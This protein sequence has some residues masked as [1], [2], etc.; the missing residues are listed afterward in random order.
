MAIQSTQLSGNTT[1][2]FTSVNSNAITAIYIC[3]TGSSIV[4]FNMYAVKAGHSADS[5]Q[6]I[7]YY[8]VSI[9]PTD[10]YVVDT[11]KLILDGNDSIVASATTS[12]N[13][14]PVIATVSYI[15]I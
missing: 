4:S 3:N 13:A 14:S 15:G 8:N 1:P 6:N 11:E 9:A 12:G 5:Q 2:I 7:I 10:T